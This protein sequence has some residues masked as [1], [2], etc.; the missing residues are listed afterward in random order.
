ML[1]KL[2]GPRAA[3]VMQCSCYVSLQLSEGLLS[4]HSLMQTFKYP[5]YRGHLV[6]LLPTSSTLRSSLYPNWKRILGLFCILFLFWIYFVKKF[7]THNFYSTLNSS[8][9]PNWKRFCSLV[10]KFL[11]YLEFSLFGYIL[12]EFFLIH[13]SSLN[14]IHI[15]NVFFILW[16]LFCLTCKTF[17]LFSICFTKFL[18]WKNFV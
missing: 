11:F 6:S 7:W 18:T 10:L 14:C 4:L 8:L 12:Q 15:E 1:L 16:K 5:W 9:Y 2:K 13:Q 3:D 17:P